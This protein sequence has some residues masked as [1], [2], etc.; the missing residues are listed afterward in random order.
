MA[1]DNHWGVD[2]IPEGAVGFV[3]RI[4]LRGK[5]YIGKKRCVTISK[6]GK[7]TPNNSWKGYTGSNKELNNDILRF[8]TKPKFEI[9]QWCGS[10]SELNYAE[11]H[12]QIHTNA[13]RDE[14][15]YNKQ[16]GSG[17]TMYHAS[18]WWMDQ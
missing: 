10:R 14:K 7:V 2:K 5:F 12:W 9:L 18:G 6:K 16:L 8:K 17:H 1:S 11:V 3:Y 15:S 13:L 4:T